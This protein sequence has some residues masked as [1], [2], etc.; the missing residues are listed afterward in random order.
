MKLSM[1]VTCGACL[2]LT[3]CGGNTSGVVAEVGD[4]FYAAHKKGCPLVLSLRPRLYST[5]HEPFHNEFHIEN[6]VRDAY[7][8]D[9]CKY[10][11][12]NL[13][14]AKYLRYNV[15]ADENTQFETFDTL[16]I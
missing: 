6:Y 1:K 11:Q 9:I 8:Q 4:K 15:Y 14:I 7:S 2:H 5:F 12:Q 13:L 10:V 3:C 16:Y